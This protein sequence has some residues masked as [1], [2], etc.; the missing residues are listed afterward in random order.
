[1][2]ITHANP[3]ESPQMLMNVKSLFFRNRLRMLSWTKDRNI[4]SPDYWQQDWPAWI[5][6]HFTVP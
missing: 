3:I 1:M 5:G 4:G 2:R 6:G